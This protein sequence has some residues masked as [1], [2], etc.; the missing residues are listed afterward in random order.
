MI[1]MQ[2][3][4][5]AWGGW[6]SA[7]C[8]IMAALMLSGPAGAQDG[9][10]NMNAMHGM[11][12]MNNTPATAQD[13]A[14]AVTADS[15]SDSMAPTATEN[16]GDDSTP[17]SMAP[18]S[19]QALAACRE[20]AKRLKDNVEKLQAELEEA[21]KQ[22]NE[23]KKTKDKLEQDIVK[24]V[25]DDI[26]QKDREIEELKQKLQKARARPAIPPKELQAMATRLRKAE[27][28]LNAVL[29]E[30]EKIVAD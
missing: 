12:G 5:G 1:R 25:N 27:K 3:N 21:I 24:L 11:R 26:S 9:G 18:T 13:T 19:G 4:A 2:G 8:L 6:A 22:R 7:M 16:R 14:P 10:G 28:R 15:A 30:L 29:D 20:E 23:Y 17:D